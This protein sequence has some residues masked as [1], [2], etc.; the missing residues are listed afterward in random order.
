MKQDLTEKVLSSSPLKIVFGMHSVNAV[1]S[2]AGNGIPVLSL[3]YGTCSRVFA[4]FSPLL[5]NL[6]F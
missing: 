5:L 3:Q 2:Y 4:T 1:L 6:R